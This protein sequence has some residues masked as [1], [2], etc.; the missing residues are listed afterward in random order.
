MA[1]AIVVAAGRGTRLGAGRPKALVP[2]AGRPMLGWCLEALL[3]VVEVRR[4]A[5][6][7]PEGQALP[8]DPAAW[9]LAPGSFA[10]HRTGEPRVLAVPGG[11]ERAHSVRAGLAALGDVGEDE[12]VL[13]QDA[14]RPMLTPAIVRACLAALEGPGVDA[15]VAAAPM[16]DTVKEAVVPG[17]AGSGA[18]APRV[19]RTLDR[20]LLWSVQTPQAFVHRALAGVLAHPDDV[21]AAATDEA[22]LVE[23]AGG[24][25]R[26]V[27]TT[28]ANRKVTGAEDLQHA[29]AALAGRGPSR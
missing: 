18:E 8:A 27:P 14:A 28:S 16:T 4:L 6:V 2:L 24:D 13:V 5:V 26:L 21:L 19:A 17:P 9:G 3:A 25:V 15:A 11:D 23:E 22:S 10:A 20:R 29:E 7:L 12:T 1:V